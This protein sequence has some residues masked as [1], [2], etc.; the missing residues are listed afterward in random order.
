MCTLC[1]A[2]HAIEVW[3]CVE[4]IHRG[5]LSVDCQ[6]LVPQPGLDF[7]AFR[8]LEKRPR[9]RCAVEQTA[10]VT[11]SQRCRTELPGAM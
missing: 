9:R 5:I 2:D 10:S 4:F 7:G 3:K 1:F 6:K 11:A 8:D